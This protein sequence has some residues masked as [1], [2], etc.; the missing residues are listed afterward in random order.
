MCEIVMHW[1]I[2]SIEQITS[3]FNL[4]VVALAVKI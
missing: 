2:I 1:V 4:L 3:A